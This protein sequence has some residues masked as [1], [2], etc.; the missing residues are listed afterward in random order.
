MNTEKFVKYP[1]TNCDTGELL[2]YVI[3]AH[4]VGVWDIVAVEVDGIVYKGFRY[5]MLNHG[6]KWADFLGEFFNVPK[7][8][9]RWEHYSVAVGCRQGVEILFDGN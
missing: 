3:T 8:K 4:A 5:T 6:S 2:G 1:C 9:N 7:P